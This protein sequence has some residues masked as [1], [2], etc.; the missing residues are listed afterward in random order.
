[1]IAAPPRARGGEASIGRPGPGTSRGNQGPSPPTI[2]IRSPELPDKPSSLAPPV[3]E[4]PR[5]Q[6]RRVRFL[7]RFVLVPGGVILAAVLAL[8]IIRWWAFPPPT[9]CQLAETIERSGGN[10][11]W[12]AAMQL[13]A[14]L[15]D[16]PQAALRRDRRLAGQLAAVLRRELTSGGQD[17]T[18]CVFLCRALGEFQ[19]DASLPVLANAAASRNDPVRRSAV[20]SLAILADRLGGDD[21]WSS[22]G[23]RDA[24]LQASRTSAPALRAAA[25]FTLGVVGNLEAQ[26]RLESM[27]ADED[28][29]VR[30]NAATALARTGNGRAVGVLLEMLAPD[31]AAA[32]AG[33]AD[34]AARIRQ[35]ET[36]HANALEAVGQLLNANPA[37]GIGGFEDALAR[38]RQS[39]PPTTI[40]ARIERLVDE[41]RLHQAEKPLL[42]L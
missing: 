14:M 26:Q 17:A 18:L 12:R 36:I 3:D 28:V 10:T 9:A 31:Q 23:V 16:P 25:A 27:L 21:V 40:L 24:I 6:P 32:L 39:R 29:I 13:A 41:D 2:P 33:A 37:I 1:V 19:V 22:S 42:A 35:R 8:A 38:L 34:E 4:T 15:A 11:R 20:E 7:V 5:P 30:Y